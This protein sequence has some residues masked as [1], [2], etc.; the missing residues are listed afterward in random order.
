MAV[1]SNMSRIT[2]TTNTS[3]T[4]RSTTLPLRNSDLLEKLNLSLHP[5][6]DFFFFHH[7]TAFLKAST[8][9]PKPITQDALMNEHDAS[10]LKATL[11][12]NCKS[13]NVPLSHMHYTMHIISIKQNFRKLNFPKFCLILFD[14]IF[15]KTKKI[16]NFTIHNYCSYLL[17]ISLS[18]FLRL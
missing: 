10:N 17:F 18:K 1:N 16:S 3:T 11:V 9:K 4:L 14:F 2:L 8:S 13:R 7:I 12:N 6:E 15:F 5:R